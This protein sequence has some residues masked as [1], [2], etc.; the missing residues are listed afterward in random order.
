MAISTQIFITVGLLTF[1]YRDIEGIGV[2][3]W[4]SNHETYYVRKVSVEN[5]KSLPQ[6]ETSFLAV[7]LKGRVGRTRLR[8]SQEPRR[9]Y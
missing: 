3:T 7:Y 4:N 1:S 2:E 9:E 8:V 5:F 6:L